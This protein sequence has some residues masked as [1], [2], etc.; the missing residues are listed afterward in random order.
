MMFSVDCVPLAEEASA[1]YHCFKCIALFLNGF[2]PHRLM[3]TL[4]EK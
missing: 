1:S 4:S 3:Q 2:P